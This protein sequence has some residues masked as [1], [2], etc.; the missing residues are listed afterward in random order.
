MVSGGVRRAGRAARSG[1]TGF[2]NILRRGKVH[3][4]GAGVGGG[5]LVGAAIS[6]ITPNPTANTVGGLL[7]AYGFGGFWGAVGYAA[8]RFFSGGLT[9]GGT[10]LSSQTLRQQARPALAAGAGV[11]AI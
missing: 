1:L 11:Q 10:T 4:V 7:G 3:D 2:R 5:I 9:F 6:R 8:L